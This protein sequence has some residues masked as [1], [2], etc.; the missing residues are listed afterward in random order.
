MTGIDT[1]VAALAR[2]RLTS[3]VNDDREQAS[4]MAKGIAE[5]ARRIAEDVDGAVAMGRVSA[6]AQDVHQL[7]IRATRLRA[8]QE[9]LELLDAMMPANGSSTERP[10]GV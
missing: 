8:N 6:L 4:R 3:Q 1:Q 9:A 10:S 5:D 7:M 2:R